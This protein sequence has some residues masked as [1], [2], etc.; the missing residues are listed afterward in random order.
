MGDLGAVPG[1]R[2]DIDM[3]DNVH[4]ASEFMDVGG[5]ECPGTVL[6]AESVFIQTRGELDLTRSGSVGH[7]FVFTDAGADESFGPGATA[8]GSQTQASWLW[9]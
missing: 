3:P 4:G 9:L 8:P 7:V 2:A 6:D 1:S 5:L